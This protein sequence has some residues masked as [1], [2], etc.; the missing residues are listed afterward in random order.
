MT[1]R[2]NNSAMDET[3]PLLAPQPRVDMINRWLTL[4][5]NLGVV[6]GLIIL[7]VEVRQ[8]AAMTRADMESRRNDVLVQIELSLAD[9]AIGAA[10]IKS[11]R[12]PETM[13]DLDIRTVESHLVA[14][15]LQWDYMFNMEEGGL[16]SRA[17]ARLHIQN[18]APF[19]FGSAHAKNWWR[20]QEAGWNGTPMY[21][22]ADP[23]IKNLDEDFMLNY[24]NGT[25]LGSAGTE[26][27]ISSEPAQLR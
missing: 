7:I 12:A 17:E 8:N 2:P 9:P 10:W 3:K 25:R 4:G 26:T 1:D 6:L 18:T 11:I 14:L 27:G 5:A 16:V 24:L 23:I 13:T 15:L 22:M 20:W 19:Y 21:D